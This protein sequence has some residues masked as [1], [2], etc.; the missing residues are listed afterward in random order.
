[1]KLT[2]ITINYNNYEGLKQTI[3]SV[4]GQTYNE[5]EYIVIDGGSTDD[6]KQLIEKFNSDIAY[7]VSEP[8][9][10]IYNAMN[11]GIMKSNGE[12]LLFLN[13]GDYLERSNTIQSVIPLLND[14]DIVYGNMVIDRNGRHEYAKSPAKL[15]FEEMIRGT[16]WH[17]VSFIKKELFT[18]Y[19]LYNEKY[20]I[21]SD[22]EFFLK[23]IYIHRVTVK[24]IDVFIS[25]FNT[26]GIGSSDK[27]KTLH[28]KEKYE[29]QTQLFHEEVIASAIRF[30]NL[31]RSK[32]QIIYN[33]IKTKPFLYSI[34]KGIYSIAKRIF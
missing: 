14:S 8:D 32:A 11:K 9:G 30:S 3:E 10:G 15:E 16:L 21:I 29:V 34:A 4:I 6:S 31:K 28:D 12:Y 1:M 18:K 23:T 17:P 19:G 33:F 13:S 27:Y 22:Y 20:K 7:W 24:Y 25:V 2:I 26:D 5:F